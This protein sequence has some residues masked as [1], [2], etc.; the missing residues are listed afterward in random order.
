MG[1]SKL[2][3]YI[4]F[5]AVLGGAVSLFDRSTR[6]HVRRKSDVFL[7][8]ISFYTKNPDILKWKLKEKKDKI[9]TV[10]EQISED[11]TYIKGQVEELKTLT[12]QVKELVVNTKEAFVDSKDEYKSI[13]SDTPNQQESDEKK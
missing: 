11:A 10:Y 3:R 7:S 12:P 13:V 6:E 5:G 8:D 2:G 9:Q 4:F 1:Q